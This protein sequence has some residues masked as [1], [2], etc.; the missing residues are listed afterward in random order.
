MNSTILNAR[1]VSIVKPLKTEVRQGVN[2]TFESKEITVRIAV[3]RNYKK[4]RTENGKN[5]EHTSDFWNCKFTGKVAENFAK[6]CTDTRGDGKLV[7]R[8]LLISGWFENYA[9]TRKIHIAPLVSINGVVHQLELDVDV[10]DD[11]ATIFMGDGFEFLDSNPAKTQANGTPAVTV[12]SATPVNQSAGTGDATP[13]VVSVISPDTNAGA[14]QQPTNTVVASSPAT[15]QNSKFVP[16][17]IEGD[18]SEDS[19]E[20]PF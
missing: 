1:T 8:H 6:Y 19:E 9:T 12:V 17:V 4:P 11:R 20:A 14:T 18:F 16:P 15:N 2:G 3:T 7:S 10:P 5:A 13:P